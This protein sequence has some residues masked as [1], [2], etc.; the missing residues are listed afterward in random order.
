M[1]TSTEN[2]GPLSNESYN[3]HS[4]AAKNVDKL[5]QGVKLTSLRQTM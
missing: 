3:L 1:E 2:Q 5:R 4:K